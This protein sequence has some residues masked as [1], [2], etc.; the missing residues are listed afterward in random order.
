MKI[1]FIFTLSAVILLFGCSKKSEHAYN[2]A[3]TQYYNSVGEEFDKL[4]A[5]FTEGEIKTSYEL[6]KDKVSRDQI[7]SDI[8]GLKRHVSVVTEH[9]EKLIPSR[10]AVEFH[11]TVNRFFGKA[12]IEFTD[13]LTEYASLDCNCP[14]KKEALESQIK[15]MYDDISGIKD[16]CTVSQKK[17]TEKTGIK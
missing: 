13:L 8:N 15:K 2:E 3:V 16:Q 6:K 7:R 14:D 17:Y 4:Y 12:G 5:K 11:N 10:E 1:K 9:F